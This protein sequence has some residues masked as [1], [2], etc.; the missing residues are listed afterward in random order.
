M[1]EKPVARSQEPVERQGGGR[2][3]QARGLGLALMLATGYW[4]LASLP[5]LAEP[6]QEDVFRSIGRN[7]SETGDNGKVLGILA[8]VA[9][10][11]VLLVVVGQRR[12]RADAG[13]KVLHSHPKLMKEVLRTV[14]L[15]PAEV[16]QLK[17]L[18]QECRAGDGGGC[19]GDSGG[20]GPPPQS[21]LTL[22]LCPSLLLKAAHARNEKVNPKV[23]AGL[24]KKLGAKA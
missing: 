1:D 21:P 22:V 19:D 24:A 16:K 10:A 9:G 17:V 15:K 5:A 14:P 6:T 13:P 20:K 12:A 18:L 2:L 4:L 3:R 23:V 8:G 11:V 7:V